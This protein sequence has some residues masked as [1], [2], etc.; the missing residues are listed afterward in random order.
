MTADRP[1]GLHGLFTAWLRRHGGEPCFRV[2]AKGVNEPR[3]HVADVFATHR[4]DRRSRWPLFRG[5]LIT[6]TSG[7]IAIGWDH[8]R[9]IIREQAFDVTTPDRPLAVCAGRLRDVNRRAKAGGD[10]V[11]TLC[12]V[13]AHE[14]GHTAQGRRL[15]GFYWALVGP[16][17]LFGEGVRWWNRWENDASANGLFG[18]IVPG[19][20]CE[21]LRALLPAGHPLLGT[22]G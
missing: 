22:E 15:G 3:W 1:R 19:S 7:V 4:R 2:Y 17:T 6:W 10:W 21:E 14:C 12:E 11:P 13:M 8:A 9:E 16:V 18:G 5:A 20:V